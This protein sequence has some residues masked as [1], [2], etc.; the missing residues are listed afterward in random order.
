MADVKISALSSASALGGTETFP[1]VQTS[2][3]KA[4][5]DQ[6]KTY[7]QT[8]VRLQGKETIWVPAG[9]MK[10]RTT[11]IRPFSPSSAQRG[12]APRRP[13]QT[14]RSASWSGGTNS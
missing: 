14:V 8:G 10:S 12:C 4:T 13:A 9:A 5:I 11:A 1:V 3:K 7:I 6:A 2:T